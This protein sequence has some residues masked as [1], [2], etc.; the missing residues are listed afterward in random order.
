MLLLMLFVMLFLIMVILILLVMVVSWTGDQLS[1]MGDMELVF[2]V[3]YFVCF[4]LL[5]GVDY[6]AWIFKKEFFMLL[7]LNENGFYIF[8]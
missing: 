6:F 5:S 1:N 3:E 2:D 8:L 7:I 4:F